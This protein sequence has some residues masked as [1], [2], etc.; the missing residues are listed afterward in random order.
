MARL[1]LRAALYAAAIGGAAAHAAQ[2]PSGSP[3]IAIMGAGVSTAGFI[4]ALR[5]ELAAKKACV[6]VFEMASSAGGRAASYYVQ[7]VPSEPSEKNVKR[8]RTR[9]AEGKQDSPILA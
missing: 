4:H 1:A 7:G 9:Q 2:C 3:S 6:T 5:E 8:E